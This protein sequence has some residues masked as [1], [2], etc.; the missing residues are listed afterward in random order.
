MKHCHCEVVLLLVSSIYR[1]LEEHLG[2]ATGLVL[3]LKKI[4]CFVV[5][6]VSVLIKVCLLL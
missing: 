4:V 6:V 2:L 1:G 5:N 3:I